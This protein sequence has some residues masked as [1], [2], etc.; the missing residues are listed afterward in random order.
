MGEDPG[1]SSLTKSLLNLRNR[2]GE[3]RRRRQT[4]CVKRDNNFVWNNFV[5]K[6]IFL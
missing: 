4:L 2:M 1:K 3:G 5:F 6:R